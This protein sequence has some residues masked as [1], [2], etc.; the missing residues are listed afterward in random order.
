MRKCVIFVLC[1]CMLFSSF[2]TPCTADEGSDKITLFVDGKMVDCAKYGQE[3]VIVEGRTL[4]PLR[5]VFEALGATVQWNNDTRTV[6]SKRENIEV[7]LSVDS[8]TLY[9]NGEAKTID[10]PPQLMNNRTMVPVRAVAEAFGC[11]VKWDNNTRSVQITSIL[12]ETP[13]K[14]MEAILAAA[15]NFDVYEILKHVDEAS[16]KE[17]MGSVKNL[18]VSLENYEFTQEETGILT[19]FLRNTLNCST[20]KVLGSSISGDEATVTVS[21]T[22]PNFEKTSIY[23][24]IGSENVTKVYESI[25]AEYGYTMDHLQSLDKEKADE[26]NSRALIKMIG[27]L[28]ESFNEVVGSVGMVTTKETVSF[29]LVNGKWLMIF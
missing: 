2:V 15:K 4:V 20:F 9:I 19:S 12:D 17:G 3:P 21:V 26:L 11:T 1:V 6:I 14:V 22:I 25:L 24:Q 29:K 18:L 28:T 16:A 10:I 27:V 5:S 23:N 13:E 7:S 8:D